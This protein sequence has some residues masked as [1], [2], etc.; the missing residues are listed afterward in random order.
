MLQCSTTEYMDV[1]H[2]CKGFLLRRSN[3]VLL[4]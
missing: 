4:T 2:V 1:K 3:L